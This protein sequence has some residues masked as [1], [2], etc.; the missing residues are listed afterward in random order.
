M[1]AIQRLVPL[2]GLCLG[3]SANFN[4]YNA[5]TLED[6]NVGDACV[7]AMAADIACPAYIRSFM[8][9]RYHGSLYNVT[10][11]DEICTGACSASLKRW[12]NT[13]V[14][15]CA[16]EDVANGVPQR[17]GGYIWAGWNETCIKDPKTKKYCN[18]KFHA[19]INENY[20]AN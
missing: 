4:I 20:M 10:L 3:A 12:F 11:T 9:R 8:Q 1:V 14:S 16:G 5:T 17:Y 13:V 18:G 19:C 6:A 15:A 2:L 7:K